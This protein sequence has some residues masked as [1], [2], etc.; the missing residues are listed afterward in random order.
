LRKLR[1]KDAEEALANIRQAHEELRQILDKLDSLREEYENWL[2]QIETN[3]PYD[4]VY[5]QQEKLENVLSINFR[6]DQTDLNAVERFFDA[7]ANVD[8]P[9]GFGRD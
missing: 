2:D 4:V 9:L 5:V 3:M 7:A 1:S 8:L 6:F